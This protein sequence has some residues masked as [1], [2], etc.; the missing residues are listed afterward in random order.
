MLRQIKIAKDTAVKA[1]AQAI[2]TL[3]TLVITAPPEL[4]EQLEGLA[5]IALIERCAGL[6]PGPMTNPLA[7]AKHAIREFARR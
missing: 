4:R 7:A 6:R 2:V 5:R 1:R 3:K